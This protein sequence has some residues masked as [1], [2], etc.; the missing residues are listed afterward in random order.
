MQPDGRSSPDSMLAVWSLK[1][2]DL[3]EAREAAWKHVESFLLE[4][5]YTLYWDE[6]GQYEPDLPA[7]QNHFAPGPHEALN[8]AVLNR[9]EGPMWSWST[10]VS[11]TTS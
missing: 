10:M 8:A 9:E 7:P 5:G 2:Y 3:A 6:D 1:E 4:R 11:L